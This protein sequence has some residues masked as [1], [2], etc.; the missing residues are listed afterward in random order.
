MTLSQNSESRQHIEQVAGEAFWKEAGS[1]YD[2]LRGD[3]AR[4]LLPPAEVFLRPDSLMAEL[5]RYPD[6]MTL[7]RGG[8]QAGGGSAGG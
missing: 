6:P 3:P 4:P 7:T 2:L 1:R 5:K 8:I